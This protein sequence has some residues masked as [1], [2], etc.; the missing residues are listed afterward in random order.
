MKQI[1]RV[2]CAKK[3]SRALE[4]QADL[5]IRIGQSRGEFPSL[6]FVLMKVGLERLAGGRLR[7]NNHHS[8]L[9][10]AH[11]VP[12][13]PFDTSVNEPVLIAGGALRHLGPRG[14]C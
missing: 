1:L 10:I 9:N 8:V 14:A 4:D 2:G 11:D 6:P 5:A 3:W 12:R 13:L 7:T